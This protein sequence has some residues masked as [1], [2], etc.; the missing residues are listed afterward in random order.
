MCILVG[1]VVPDV[2]KDCSGFSLRVKQFKKN[3]FMKRNIGWLM[4]MV[5]D[6]RGLQSSRCGWWM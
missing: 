3:N 6:K 4:S 1:Q 5:N 2:L